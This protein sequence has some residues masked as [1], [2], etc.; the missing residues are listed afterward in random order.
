MS[1]RRSDTAFWAALGLYTAGCLLVLGQ[2]A[3]AVAA[4]R[5]PGLHETLH[6]QGLGG[7]AVGRIALRT[8]DAAH[9]V[10]GGPQVAIDA[11]L[12]LLH[13]T[14]AGVLLWLRPRDRCARLL[15]TAFVGAAGTLNLTAQAVLEQLPLTPLESAA[16][17]TASI[18]AGLAYVYAL[19][20]FPDGRPVPRWPAARL[21][22][23]YLLVTAAV[24]GLSVRAE[25]AARPSVL[26]LTFGLLVPAAAIAA[27]GYRSLRTED[28]TGQAQARL[29]FWALLPTA[30]FGLVFLG[31]HG[32]S[33]TT[34]LLPGRHLAE[35][36]VTLYRSFQPAFAFIPLALFAGLSRH[37]L[38]DI[39][40]LVSRTAVYAVATGFLGGLYL[41]A[42]V[43]TQQTLGTVVSTPLVQSRVAVALSTLALVWLFRPVRDRIQRFV[44]QRFHRSRYDAQRTIESFARRLRDEVE[45]ERIVAEL[46]AVLDEV[47]GPRTSALWLR[48]T[49]ADP[50]T[51]PAALS[52]PAGA[53]APPPHRRGARASG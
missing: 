11:A 44:D 47:V 33:T 52:R 24:V 18:V 51:P 15:A 20:L 32:L 38:W 46:T 37:R 45:T 35:A 13:L 1:A 50:D 23:L 22:P 19:L 4:S 17:A 14:L 10:P 29:V 3:L 9:R 28:P 26:L 36:P 25:G 2:G 39:E 6:V 48:P 40:R 41:L 7:G 34:A 21:A 42:V 31:T 27:Q 49:T 30:A 16:Q 43:V 12:S 8:A 53:E 5:S